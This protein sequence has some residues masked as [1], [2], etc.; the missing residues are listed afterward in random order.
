AVEWVEEAFLRSYQ[1]APGQC[2]GHTH[3]NL[4]P[5]PAETK[6]VWLDGYFPSYNPELLSELVPLL[7]IRKLQPLGGSLRTLGDGKDVSYSD[8]LS[9]FRK[10]DVVYSAPKTRQATCRSSGMVYSA[11][12]FQRQPR[13]GAWMS[14]GQ[15]P[16]LLWLLLGSVEHIWNPENETEQSVRVFQDQ[17]RLEAGSV[18]E[19][20]SIHQRQGSWCAGPFSTARAFLANMAHPGTLR[21]VDC[22]TVALLPQEAYDQLSPA[23]RRLL[24]AYLLRK[25]P[26]YLHS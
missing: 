14:E 15:S 2:R 4:R 25:W 9:Q 24:N 6:T 5:G 21:A 3:G 10:G 12:K 26:T 17:N 7:E 20:A 22:S 16:P 8:R 19:K 1:P 11:P 13:G 23:L 18:F